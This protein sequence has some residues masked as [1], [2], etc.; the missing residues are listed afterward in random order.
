MKRNNV[1]RGKPAELPGISLR[2]L[3]ALLAPYKLLV[4][5][6]MVGLLGGGAVNLI[7][8]ELIRRHINQHGIELVESQLLLI[9]FGLTGLFLL[10]ALLFYLRSLVLGIVGHKV[11]FDLRK[12]LYHSILAQS[13]SF[14]DRTRSGDLVSRLIADCS[15]VQE[16]VSLRFS[17]FLRYS[18]QVLLGTALMLA[19]S[20]QLTMLVV[21]LL[22]ILVAVS[23]FLGRR[24]RKIS[25]Q[26]Q[27]ELG[28]A[29]VAA[30]ETFG[31]IR[32]V[33]AFHNSMQELTRFVGFSDRVLQLGISRQKIAAFYAS[34]VSFLMNVSMVIVLVFG[35]SMVSQEALPAGDLTAFLL[36]GAIVA[37]SFAFI[38]GSYGEFMQAL[39]A[40]ER[41]FEYIDLTRVEPVEDQK[42]S[43]DNAR[44]AAL[45][46]EF[47][48]VVFSY[49]S[50][51]D[52]HALDQVSF[53]V[54][55][56]NRVALVGRSGAGKSTVFQLLLGLYSPQQGEILLG[57]QPASKL[58]INYR[59][60]LFGFVPQ[61][62]YFFHT[63]IAENLKYGKSDASK[64]ELLDALEQVQL[65]DFVTGLPLGLETE[66]GERGVQLSG[67]QKQRLAIA[68]M[69]LKDPP[70]LLLDEP[71]SSLDSES[72]QLVQQGLETL[73]RGRTT[74][75][76]A[77]RLSTIQDF[78]RIIVFDTG[79]IIQDGN[80]H[81]LL[82][83]GGAYQKMV[84][85]QLLSAW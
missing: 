29:S 23:L 40:A 61:E 49:P 24:L 57:R 9:V 30:E 2:R 21:V 78:D 6:G 82:Q 33:K 54:E 26:Q 55:E 74:L 35:I 45:D 66:I 69:L 22:P 83:N 38:A 44:P 64:Q 50:R 25:K 19:I 42:G 46:L 63:S 10:Q 53:S 68:R 77:H 52:F 47:D 20:W 41:V 13:V 43:S 62:S 58:P 34:F 28:Q 85:L 80:H 4:A 70:I 18:F 12:K 5:L 51:P 84:D 31:N 59:R 11:V 56:G 79:K 60:Q 17:V 15:M 65:L 81:D 16:A 39:G 3:L 72:E 75:M 1:S 36:Y 48:K 27:E 14:F 67:G 71:T 7:I 8:P 76:I 73:M 32:L 37:I